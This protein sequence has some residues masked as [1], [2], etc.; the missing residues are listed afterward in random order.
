MSS[1]SRPLPRR[2]LRAA[3]RCRQQRGERAASERAGAMAVLA[4]GRTDLRLKPAQLGHRHE[5]KASPVACE[6]N[7][8][9]FSE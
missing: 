1:S 6:K 7:S 4:H 5:P 9:L 3:P 2:A 8:F